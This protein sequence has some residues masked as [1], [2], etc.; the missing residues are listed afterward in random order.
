MARPKQVTDDQLMQA[1]RKVFL[2]KGAK[3][4]VSAIAKEL[5]VTPAA[6]FHR[7]KSKERMLIDA[8][9]PGNPAE[10]AMLETGPVP[11]IDVREQL[12]EI[13][14]GLTSYLALAVPA[15][16]LLHTAGVPLGRKPR[17]KKKLNMLSLHIE[18]A[19][20]LQRAAARR[21]IRIKIPAIAAEALLGALETRYLRGYLLGETFTPNENRAFI[22]ELV[23]EVIR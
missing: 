19:K 6:L 9:W 8:L 7:Y 22:S 1:A 10:L 16:F 12:V 23:D 17:N 18:L 3:A 5:K 2:K 20:W 14:L 21:R 15:M 4:P 13:L 11:R